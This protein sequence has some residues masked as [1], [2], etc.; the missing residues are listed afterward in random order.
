MSGYEPPPV[1]RRL[2][3][4]ERNVHWLSLLALWVSAAVAAVIVWHVAM[5]SDWH[6]LPEGQLRELRS[7]AL[8]AVITAAITNYYGR[9]SRPP[10]AGRKQ[11]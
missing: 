9:R 5:P 3:Q 6:F 11:S 8:T 4:W 10:T 1:L 2:E 7:M